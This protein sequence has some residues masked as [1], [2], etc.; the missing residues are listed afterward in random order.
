MSDDRLMANYSFAEDEYITRMTIYAGGGFDGFTIETNVQTYPHILGT[1]GNLMPPAKGQRML[2]MLGELK[3]I[4]GVTV[5]TGVRI[6]FDA[7]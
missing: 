7:C 2:F 1:K 4:P 3:A 6:Y 5:V